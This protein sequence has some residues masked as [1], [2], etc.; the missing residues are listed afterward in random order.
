MIF[1]NSKSQAEK[2]LGKNFVNPFLPSKINPN[3]TKILK[4][5]VR[6]RENANISNDSLTI[7]QERKPL[8]NHQRQYSN[9][10]IGIQDLDQSPLVR[11]QPAFDNKNL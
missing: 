3:R 11:Y 1:N 6:I 7:S 2:R 10:Y 8:A 9:S 5:M 4:K